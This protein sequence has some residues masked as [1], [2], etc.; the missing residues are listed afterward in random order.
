MKRSIAKRK[1]IRF[2]GVVPLT[3][4]TGVLWD[5]DGPIHGSIET[6]SKLKRMG[7]QVFCATNNSSQTRDHYV[8]KCE[9][10]G[11]AA[12]KDEVLCTAYIAAKY[13]HA[14]NFQGKV[15]MIGGKDSMGAELDKVGIEYICPGPD[16]LEGG[17]YSEWHTNMKL[18][19]E[20]K[21]VLVGYDPD[22][23]YMKM[24]RAAS[25]LKNPDCLYLVTNEDNTFPVKDPNFCIPDVGCIS[26]PISMASGRVP[27]VM[28]KPTRNMFEVLRKIH[29]LDPPR[30]M[31]VG[32]RKDTD[33]MFAKNCGMRSLLVLSGISTI[34]DI[35]QTSG[36]SGMEGAQPDFY[37]ESLASL[38]AFI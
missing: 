13:L 10:Y 17:N 30:C 35:K 34:A 18:D 22:F 19:P 29:N 23:S 31:M 5:A 28:G 7:K 24:M 32:D 33:M 3:S 27:I 2:S 15:Y 37:A 4:F 16:P 26:K 11:Y 25:Y 8:K 21:C 14:S 12:E 20:V 9:S 6:V 36:K 1:L 38:G